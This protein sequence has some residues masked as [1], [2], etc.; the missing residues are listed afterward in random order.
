MYGSDRQGYPFYIKIYGLRQEIISIYGNFCKTIWITYPVIEIKIIKD[1]R[2]VGKIKRAIALDKER[3]AIIA[4]AR[5]R[6]K[7]PNDNWDEIP[8]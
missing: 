1:W 3:R 6:I 5:N 7:F 8:F 4:T 2:P